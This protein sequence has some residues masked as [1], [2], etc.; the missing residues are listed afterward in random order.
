MRD[1]RRQ[2]ARATAILV[3][4]MPVAISMDVAELPITYYQLT[5]DAM[6]LSVVH[7]THSLQQLD[8]TVDNIYQQKS[9]VWRQ[10]DSLGPDVCRTYPWSVW[11]R[12]HQETHR[13]YDFL[14]RLRP[15]FETVRAQLLTRHPC[16]TLVEVPTGVRA[17]ETRLRGAA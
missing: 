4:N 15:E 13:L 12:A 8:A 11:L 17:K 3:G 2:K 10:L 14:T 9:A 5:S 6:Y 7:Q 16:S 1:G